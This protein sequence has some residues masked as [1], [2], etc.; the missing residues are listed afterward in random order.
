MKI[1]QITPCFYPAWS[2]GGIPRVVYELSRSLVKAGNTLIALTTDVFNKEKRYGKRED[3]I[4]GIEALYFPNISNIAAYHYQ[5]YLPMGMRKWLSENS[6]DIDIAHM[7][8]HR[9]FLNTIALGAFK[10]KHIP[11][12][13]SGH[14]TVLKI[15]RRIALKSVFDICWG[16]KIIENASHFIAVSENEAGQYLSIGIPRNKISIVHNGIDLNAFNQLPAK[17]TFMKKYNLNGKKIVLYLG[18]ITQGKGIDILVQAFGGLLVKNI[19]LI[20]AGN[21]MGFKLQIDKLIRKMGLQEK[22]IFAGLLIDSEKLSAYVDADVL[23]Y[24]SAFDVFGLVPFEAIMSGTPVI[25]TDNCGCGEI[26]RNV[27]GGYLVKYG[28]VTGLRNTI[29]EVLK[30]REEAQEKVKNGQAFIKQNLG[31]D[32]I[33]HGIT[34]V[35]KKV[36]QEYGRI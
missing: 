29:H 4:E 20:I 23:I 11:Y 8:G 30:N 32:K 18:Q 27:G 14:G 13:F 35:Y 2:Y 25:V 21:D 19:V 10:K 34:E 16:N 3:T 5:M 17:G 1:L 6:G 22:V 33:S 24:P 15:A 31:W 12:V 7:N 28:D 26:I 36:I 9:H